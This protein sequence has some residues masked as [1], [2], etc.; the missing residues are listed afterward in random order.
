MVLVKYQAT[1]VDTHFH[2]R[3]DLP[4][5]LHLV[6]VVATVAVVGAEEGVVV[7]A[8]FVG[9]LVVVVVEVAVEVVEEVEVE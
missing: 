6:V 9:A 1:E 2:P 4:I 5:T 7:E 3:K 8:V